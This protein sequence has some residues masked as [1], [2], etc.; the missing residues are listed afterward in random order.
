M[1]Q[2]EKD[3]ALEVLLLDEPSLTPTVAHD[4]WIKHFD[5]ALDVSFLM[6]SIMYLQRDVEHHNAYKMT[7]HLKETFSQQARTKRY[8]IF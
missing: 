5:D 8:E 1:K 3:Y 6:L 2:E 4:A 7:K